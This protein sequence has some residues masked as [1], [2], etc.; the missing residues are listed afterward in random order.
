M[1]YFKIIVE[2]YWNHRIIFL[3]IDRTDT[4]ARLQLHRYFRR[5]GRRLTHNRNLRGWYITKIT[6]IYPGLSPLIMAKGLK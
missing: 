2:S 4:D 3:V 6:R 5:R 1:R